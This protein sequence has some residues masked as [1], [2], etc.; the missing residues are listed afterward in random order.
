VKPDDLRKVSAKLPLSASV[1]ARNQVTTAGA[2]NAPQIG[3][4]ELNPNEELVTKKWPVKDIDGKVVAICTAVVGKRIK[5]GEPKLRKW[6]Q[7]WKERLEASGEWTHVKAQSLRVRLASGAWYKGDI[8]AVRRADNRVC[9]FEVKGG[10]KMK[11]VAKGIL[12]LK[13]AASLYQEFE[14]TLVWKDSGQWN[15]QK[16]LP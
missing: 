3:H 4:Y 8:S 5:Q 14:W 7:E 15:Q 6:E 16:V 9:V 11:G 1:L 2:H 13:V 10:E 12:A